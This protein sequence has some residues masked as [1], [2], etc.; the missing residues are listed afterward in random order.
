MK[1]LFMIGIL[2]ISCSSAYAKVTV[3]TE[4]ISPDESIVKESS[5]DLEI[6]EKILT[7]ESLSGAV[8][9]SALALPEH[10]R[11]KYRYTAYF[12]MVDS[13]RLGIGQ[14]ISP[15]ND[16]ESTNILGIK[17]KKLILISCGT[18]DEPSQWNKGKCAKAIKKSFGVSI[19]D[20]LIKDNEQTLALP[21]N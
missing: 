19:T 1:N 17:D 9:D 10:I 4:I 21:E 11:K 6:S 20:Q 8:F 15:N 2:W 14:M 13:Y 16:A 18:Q 3:E 7:M 12:I 5:S